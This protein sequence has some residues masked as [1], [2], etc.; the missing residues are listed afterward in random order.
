MKGS[1]AVK[2]GG[3][4]VLA[5]VGWLVEK[6]LDRLLRDSGYKG[7]ANNPKTENNQE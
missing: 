1:W 7:E 4:I 3:I 6:I 5:V 2:G